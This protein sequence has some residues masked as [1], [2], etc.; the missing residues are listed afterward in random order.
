MI[1]QGKAVLVYLEEDNI[2]KAYFRIRPLLTEDGPV[3]QEMLSALPDEGYL[4]IVPDRNEQHTFKERMRNMCG[5]CLLDLRNQPAEANKIRTNKN[6]SPSNGENN[7]FIVY[8]DAV[9]AITPD[10]F[11]QV[12]AEADVDNAAT[13]IVYIRNGANMQGPVSKDAPALSDDVK[14][15]PPDSQGLHSISHNGHELLFYW[16]KAATVKAEPETVVEEVKAEEA[17][18]EEK[19]AEPANDQQTALDQIQQMNADIVANTSNKINEKPL[20]SAF[21]PQQQPLN[22]TKLYCSGQRNPNYRRAHNALMETVE[23]Q[24]YAAKQEAPGAV[25]ENAGALRDVQNPVD[26][27]KRSVQRVCLNSDDCRQAVEIFLNCP[28]M[29]QA[30]VDAV[31]NDNKNLTAVAMQNQLQEMEAERLMVLMQLDDAKK[32]MAALKEKALCELT[33]EEKNA[34]DALNAR[35]EALKKELL[36]EEKAILALNEKR[37]EAQLDFEK[38]ANDGKSLVLTRK[39]GENTDAK[40]LAQRLSSAMQAYG[41]ICDEE[42]AYAM[43]TAYALCPDALMFSA[44]NACDA[45]LACQAFAAA[46]DAPVALHQNSQTILLSPGGNTPAFVRSAM[47]KDCTALILHSDLKKED[48][49]YNQIPCAMLH[50]TA[51][52]DATPIGHYQSWPISVASLNAFLQESKLDESTIAALKPLR[53]V[54]PA[55]PLPILS[56]RNALRFVSATQNIL[57]GGVSE[58]IDRAVSL[59]ILPYYLNC[60]VKKEQLSDAL[61]ALPRSLKIWNEAK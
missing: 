6:Y 54:C 60:G 16:P 38:A 31:S 29:R 24:R 1:F 15:L 17:K 23:Q 19:P 49:L 8:S 27:F 28:G 58:A 44:A 32:D 43:L 52:M 40:T 61:S 53:M 47:R 30:V 36:A 51:D 42:D 4:R 21:V 56:Y 55:F 2:T 48:A 18:A 59:F 35:K 41:F 26:A 11:Y 46:F 5:L 12:I 13:P 37:S 45:A 39:I 3:S 10:I 50:M 25:V 14:Q 7:Q 20:P 57:K 33:A 34:L 22:G 9:R